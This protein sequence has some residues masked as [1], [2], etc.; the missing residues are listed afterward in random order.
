MQNKEVSTAYGK[1]YLLIIDDPISSFDIENKVGIMSFLK[2]QLGQFLLG[3]VDTR[4]IIMT[5][6]L[7]TFYDLNKIYEELIESCNNKYQGQQ[8]KFN[9]FE[10]AQ[11]N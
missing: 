7:L 4:A 10:L 9:W 8:L 11:Q 2:Y 3:N 5:H 1:E 6:D